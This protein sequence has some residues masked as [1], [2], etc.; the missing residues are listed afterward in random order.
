[1]VKLFLGLLLTVSLLSM[2]GCAVGRGLCSINYNVDCGQ[3]IKRAADA[4]TIQLA[5]EEM[6]TVIKYL[7]HHHM[8]EG[9]TTVIRIWLPP[10]QDVGFWYRNLKASL[11]ELETM[12]DDAP[13]QD[14][15][16]VLL[17]L[18]ET[19]MDHV[20]GKEIVTQPSGIS[21]FPNNT[22]W[23]VAEWAI[24]FML[25]ISV[26]GLLVVLLVENQ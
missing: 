9:Y 13:Q 22:S 25:L 16:M 7:E 26:G 1:M 19:L 8:T 10:E 4:N 20:E 24:G 6:T 5:R 23:F 12:K 3:H 14:K 21:V 2:G 18:R 17:K 11:E 15:A